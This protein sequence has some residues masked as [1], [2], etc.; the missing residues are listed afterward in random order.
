MNKL[1]Q[2]PQFQMDEISEYSISLPKDAEKINSIIIKECK[3]INLN[4]TKLTITDCTACV[5]GNTVPF[6]KIF[7][8]VNAVEIN[9]ERFKMLENNLKLSDYSNYILY[10]D[11]YLNMCDTLNQDII[12]IDPPW[13]G[14]NYKLQKN[15]E[16]ELGDI[17]LNL[18]VHILKNFAN[19][20]FIKL[21]L[22]YNLE[23]F[24]NVKKKIYTLNKMI[25][26]VISVIE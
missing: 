9:K 7:K 21:P 23:S 2:H 8:S 3:K 15:I 6:C 14:K 11:N 19:L 25:I 5:G 17:K 16:L 22:N 12:F 20:I 10:N 24:T 1:I 26:L 4:T 13:G 18:L